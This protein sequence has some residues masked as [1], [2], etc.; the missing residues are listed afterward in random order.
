MHKCQRFDL[1]SPKGVTPDGLFVW[2]RGSGTKNTMVMLAG[3][4]NTKDTMSLYWFRSP[5]SKT[6]RLVVG[7]VLLWMELVPERTP[8][9]ALYWPADKVDGPGVQ[10]G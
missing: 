1:S 3:T 7:V 8:L 10:V 2:W 5:G 4:Q 9:A 6:L